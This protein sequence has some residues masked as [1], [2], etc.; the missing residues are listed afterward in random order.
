MLP[1]NVTFDPAE[2]SK[3]ITG[4]EGP[5]IKPATS[6]RVFLPTVA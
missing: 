2:S 5:L 6:R 3:I 1:Q 4:V